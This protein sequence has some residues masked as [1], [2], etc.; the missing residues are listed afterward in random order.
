MF[1]YDVRRTVGVLYD[2]LQDIW[3]NKSLSC[4]YV[5]ARYVGT[6]N[7]VFIHYPGIRMPHHHDHTIQPWSETVN[8]IV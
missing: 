8:S 3:Y 4:G 7:G 5:N 2:K 6:C 1:Q